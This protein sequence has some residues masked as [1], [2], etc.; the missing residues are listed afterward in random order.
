MAGALVVLGAGSWGTALA[1]VAASQQR[2]VLWARSAATAEEVARH[3]TNARYLP[4]VMLSD[5]LEATA[6]LPAALAGAS[7][8]L[9]GVPSQHLR[10]VLEAAGPM[11]PEGTPVFSLAKGIEADTSLRMTEVV[12]L[13]VPQAVPGVVSGPNLAL[14]IA[15]GQPAAALVACAD[16][17]RAEAVR[18]SLHS[19]S[20]R[21]YATTDVVGVEVAGATKN[22]LAIAAGISDGLGLGENSRAMLITR[23]LAEM[24]RLGVTLGGHVLTFGGL[25]GIGDLIATATS[26]LSRN[27]SVGVELG[28][29]RNLV[30]IIDAMHMVAEG[31]KTAGP[32]ARLA[33]G[34]GLELPICEE[35]AKI[36]AGTTTPTEAL[37]SL[38]AR[39]AMGE[40]DDLAAI[41]AA[42]P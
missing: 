24:G 39:P 32:L 25:A 31:V 35:V 33:A 22:V 18:A 9:L 3:R 17:D 37:A 1:S 19:P 10:S 23:G 16:P 28:R 13:M 40:F 6:D 38:M 21:A 34:A 20:F 29:G 5:A 2:T 36:V 12:S 30:D 11:I 27:R 15:R 42:R 14:E 8:V 41:R 4:G 26:D 7:A